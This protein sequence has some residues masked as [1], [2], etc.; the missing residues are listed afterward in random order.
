MVARTDGHPGVIPFSVRDPA[1]GSLDVALS[2]TAMRLVLARHLPDCVNGTLRLESCRPVSARY[3]PSRRC[4]VRY[5]LRFRD[6]Q[7]GSKIRTLAHAVL[8]ADET[9]EQLWVSRSLG[10]VVERA[11]RRHPRPPFARATYVPELRAIVQLYPVDLFL[12]GLVD[13]AASAPM[14][15]ALHKALPQRMGR[16]PRGFQ[17]QL[18]R[19]K[20]AKRAVLRYPLSD[21]ELSAVY[22]KVYPDDRGPALMNFSRV[23]RAAGVATPEPLAYLPKLRMVM[24]SEARGQ[25]LWQLR[26]TNGF[27]EWLGAAARALAQL[28]G[29]CLEGLPSGSPGNRAASVLIAAETIGRLLPN[30]AAETARLALKVAG[31]LHAVPSPAVT[32]HGDFSPI[33]L[34]TSGAGVVLLDLDDLRRGHPLIDV[35]SFAVAL[36]VADGSSRQGNEMRDT[37]VEAYA[38]ARQEALEQVLLFEAAEMLRAALIPFRLLRMDWPAQTERLVQLARRRFQEYRRSARFPGVGTANGRSS[39][40][41]EKALSFD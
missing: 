40:A 7:A 14:R 9:A 18:V 28:H 5:K 41:P 22:G 23:L 32:I 25:Q 24:H 6:V 34:L 27:P 12:G 37:F 30:I 13:A 17:P 31:Q 16:A 38:T 21:S 15:R 3:D 4:L 8:Y 26:L 39:P 33:Q 36:S 1:L 35:A 29:T 19:Y 2:A 10:Y 11:A 20:P